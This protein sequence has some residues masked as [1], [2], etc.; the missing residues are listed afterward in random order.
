[1][2]YQYP[3]NQR[4]V[5]R[6]AREMVKHLAV[7]DLAFT[8]KDCMDQADIDRLAA[9]VDSEAYPD[10]K[11]KAEELADQLEHELPADAEAHKFF[12]DYSSIRDYI[13]DLQSIGWFNLGFQA[14]LRL[15]GTPPDFHVINGAA[16]QRKRRAS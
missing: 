8:I 5:E 10:L 16:T 4:R 1:M 7:T 11:K 6:I 3:G 14:A 9:A 2:S 15:M 13:E 12:I